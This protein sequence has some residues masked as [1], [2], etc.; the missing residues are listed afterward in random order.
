MRVFFR[1]PGGETLTSHSI[2]GNRRM[3]AIWPYLGISPVTTQWEWSPL[4]H[5]AYKRNRQLFVPESSA[6][7]SHSG[8]VENYA[9]SIPGLLALHVRRGDFQEHCV[10]L[11]KW[12]SNWN[13]FNMFPEFIDKYQTGTTEEETVQIYLTHCF[14]TIEEIVQKVTQV[15][16]ESEQPLTHIY[17]MTNGPVAWVAELKEALGSSGD[18]DQIE[19]S[20]DLDLTWEQKYVAQALDMFV[21]QRAEV[22]IGNGVRAIYNFHAGA[23]LTNASSQWSSLTSNVVMLRMAQ[24]FPPNSNRFW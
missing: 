9:E 5:D 17:V 14:P 3:L 4:I 11:A 10:N 12:S 22:L 18:W 1:L 2:L 16:I 21:A 6:R 23:R 15:R 20:R 7:S 13:A 19:T 8:L 24:D